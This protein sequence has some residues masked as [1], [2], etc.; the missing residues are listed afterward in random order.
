MLRHA[1]MM[2]PR[3]TQAIAPCVG[4][5]GFAS[6]APAQPPPRVRGKAARR[7]EPVARVPKA[8]SAAEAEV[9][10]C[11]ARF[12]VAQG[13]A[14]ATNHLGRHLASTRLAD[15]SRTMLELVAA[16]MGG[17]PQFLRKHAGVFAAR[18]ADPAAPQPPGG[19]G[20]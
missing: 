3:R 19:P 14:C 1:L 8:G 7:G 15:G 13:G 18:G 20:V 12:A 4:R 16:Q 17:V 2:G 10:R 5:L 11:S 9:V 6:A